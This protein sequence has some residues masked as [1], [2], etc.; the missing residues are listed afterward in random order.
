MKTAIV[1]KVEIKEGKNGKEL[2]FVHIEGKKYIVFDKKWKD[3]EEH[4]VKYNT[5]TN[6]QYTN[7]ELIEILGK[8]ENNE[9]NKNENKEEQSN[10]TISNDKSI[11]PIIPIVERA[12]VAFI[13]SGIITDLDSYMEFIEKATERLESFLQEK[14]LKK[15]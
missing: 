9:D 7:L 3:L 4:L 2:I 14:I 11:L 13:G 8:K 5:S 1:D 15:S 10:G 6:G 12:A